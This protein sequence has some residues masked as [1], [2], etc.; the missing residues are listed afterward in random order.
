MGP[1]WVDKFRGSKSFRD[2]VTNVN[3]DTLI[4]GE[5]PG[6]RLPK[7]VSFPQPESVSQRNE[8]GL[9]F[10]SLK[11]LIE[12]KLASGMTAAHRLQDMADVMNLIRVN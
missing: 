8:E 9:P 4:V 6:D 2:A 12:L 11:T 10:I 3:V 1:G 5:Y 7:P